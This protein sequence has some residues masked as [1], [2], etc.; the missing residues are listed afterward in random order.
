MDDLFQNWDNAGPSGRA[1]QGGGYGV[2]PAQ[3]TLPIFF[4]ERKCNTRA[5]CDRAE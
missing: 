2:P 1:A 5:E 3:R 4:S